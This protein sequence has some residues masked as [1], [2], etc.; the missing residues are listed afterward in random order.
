MTT[1]GDIKQSIRAELA[2]YYTPAEIRELTRWLLEKEGQVPAHRLLWT[3]E[4]VPDEA[5]ARVRK[6][7][8]RLRAHEP[9]QYIIGEAEFDGRTFEVAP[10]VLIPRPETV[11][12]VHCVVETEAHRPVRIV[13]IGTGS[14][15]IAIS[16]AAELPQ[17]QVTGLDISEEALHIARRN[18]ARNQVSVEWIHQDILSTTADQALGVYDCIVSNPPY[19]M[20]KERAGMARNVLDYEPEEAL[21]VPDDDPLLFYRRIAQWGKTHLHEGGRLYF[22][23]NEQCGPQMERLLRGMG[24]QH[25]ELRQDFYGKDRIIKASK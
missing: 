2:T 18:A 20:E 15:C 4:P 12:L 6:A 10:G 3:D 9:I 24:Y 1:I 7:V 5:E 19:V 8:G 25:I 14:G 17:A 21:F 22:E 13:D 16:L 11:E 23:I